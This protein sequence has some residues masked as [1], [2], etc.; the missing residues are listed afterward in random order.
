MARS[1]EE[2]AKTEAELQKEIVSL[3]IKAD[4]LTAT[5]KAAA[6]RLKHLIEEELSFLDMPNVKFQVDIQTGGFTSSGADR[7]EFLISPNLGEEL[8]PLAKIAS[9]GELSR[10]MLAIKSI[11]G[12]ADVVD[13]LIFDEIDT[14]VSGKAAQKI[15]YKMKRIAERKQTICVTH[16]ASIAALADHHLKISKNVKK[17]KTYTSVLPLDEQGRVDELAVIMGGM[18]VTETTKAAARDL[19]DQA[20]KTGE[21]QHEHL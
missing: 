7:V 6:S 14:G 2:I 19:L 20:I 16:L 4:K 11:L 18:N 1:E 3:Q 15:G 12:E 9:G 17:N 5:R 13:T 21:L 10:I 8:K